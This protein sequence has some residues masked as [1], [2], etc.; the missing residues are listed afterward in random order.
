MM[1]HKIPDS[2]LKRSKQ[3]YRAPIKNAFILNNTPDFVREMLKPDIFSKAGIFNFDSISGII[4]KIEKTNS[5]TEVEDMI[6]ASVMSTHL[7]YCQFIE[8]KNEEFKNT[9][10]SNLKLIKDF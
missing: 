6:L 4:S 7:L 8:K 5:S 9:R 10:L 3:A 2:I 1:N